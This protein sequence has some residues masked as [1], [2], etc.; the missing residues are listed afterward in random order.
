L[1]D[2]LFAS[3][4]KVLCLFPMRELIRLLTIVERK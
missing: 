2:I 4:S 1:K 3:I